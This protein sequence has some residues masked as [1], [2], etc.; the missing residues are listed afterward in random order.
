MRDLRNGSVDVGPDDVV[1]MGGKSPHISRGGRGTCGGTSG[2]GGAYVLGGESENAINIGEIPSCA[3]R[4]TGDEV[5]S[6]HVATV[7]PWLVTV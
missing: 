2:V 1:G 3:A 7:L 4:V 6:D 5:V